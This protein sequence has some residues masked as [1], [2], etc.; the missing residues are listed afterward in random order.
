MGFDSVRPAGRDRMLVTVGAENGSGPREAGIR[1]EPS[2][3]FREKP[4]PRRRKRWSRWTKRLERAGLLERTIERSRDRVT[5][6]RLTRRAGLG[7]TNMSDPN[8][9]PST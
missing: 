8:S 5:H 6:V 1:Y 9:C 7:W 3:W 2:N 4:T